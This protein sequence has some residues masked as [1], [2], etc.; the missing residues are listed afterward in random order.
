MKRIYLEITNACNLNCKFCT[1]DK[2]HNFI[3]IET[4]KNY[5]KQ[6]KEITD[7]IYLHVLGEPL[8]HKDI[9]ELL[10]ILD[11]Y[12]MNLQLVTNGILLKNHLDILNHKCLRKLSISL[13]SI[14]NLNIDDDYFKTLNYLIENNNNKVVELRLYGNDK[15]DDKLNNFINFLNKKYQKENTDKQNSY[16][17]KEN[18]FLYYS[19]FFKW[20]NI[21][22]EY[23]G[24]TGK[25]Q[26]IKN[27]LAI[28]N[29][30]T[31]TSCCLDTKGINSF[32]NLNEKSLKEILNSANY[33]NALKDLNNNKLSLKL[34]KH[35]TYH[36]R[37]KL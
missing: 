5:I 2:G 25:C 29:D 18:V 34:C 23:I 19:D 27:Q 4:F 36:L 17:L 13:H 31:V 24:D 8:L 11:E 12:D 32:G 9:K 15:L 33:L 30:G 14:N 22:D 37:F 35:C 28:L 7:Y 20:P 3:D 6:I 21:N 16:K 26:G 10:N 1:Q